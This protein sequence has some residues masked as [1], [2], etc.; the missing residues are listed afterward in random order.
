VIEIKEFAQN[1]RCEV[2]KRSI[3]GPKAYCQYHS[4]A[5]SNLKGRFDEWKVALGELSWERYLET[6]TQL[7]EAGDWVKQVAKN[8]LAKNASQSLK[9]VPD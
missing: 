7:E 8:E 9:M 4:V 3:E 2:C 5:Y 1:S 6:I